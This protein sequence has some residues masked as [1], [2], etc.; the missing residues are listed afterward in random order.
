MRIAFFFA[1]Y[2][3]QDLLMLPGIG[4]LNEDK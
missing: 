1:T 2:Q 3:A 4:A